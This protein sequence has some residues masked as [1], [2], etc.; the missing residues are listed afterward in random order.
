MAILDRQLL[1]PSVGDVTGTQLHELLGLGGMHRPTTWST[2]ATTL[3][4]R[5]SGHRDCAAADGEP[6]RPANRRSCAPSCG[7]LRSN[8]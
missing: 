5:G 4:R 7:Q 6:H 2:L 3:D 8:G 1:G